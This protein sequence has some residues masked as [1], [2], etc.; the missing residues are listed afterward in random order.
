MDFLPTLWTD[1]GA[2]PRFAILARQLRISRELSQNELAKAT[3]LSLSTIRAWET[4]R[5]EPGVR[6]LVLWGRVLELPQGLASAVQSTIAAPRIWVSS[7]GFGLGSFLRERRLASGS[8]LL[9]VATDLGLA[10]TTL[11]HYETGR[12]EAPPSVLEALVEEYALKGDE[13]E[14]VRGGSRRFL[15]WCDALAADLDQVGEAVNQAAWAASA[16]EVADRGAVFVRLRTGL[17]RARLRGRGWDQWD[18]QVACLHTYWL[19]TEGRHQDAAAALA[20]ARLPETRESGRHAALLMI[21]RRHLGR[22]G[23]EQMLTLAEQVHGVALSAWLRGEAA[24]DLC[25]QRRGG[26]AKEV[27]A[28]AVSQVDALGEWRESWMR[29]RDV[30]RVA[31]RTRDWSL[32]AGEIDAMESLEPSDRYPDGWFAQQRGILRDRLAEGRATSRSVRA[33]A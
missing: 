4:G 27:V 14:A 24:L 28:Q 15:E 26:E 31:L 10:R 17:L 18:R 29:R 20:G 7:P 32:A 21:S 9:Q 23:A 12:L 22:S 2:I 13:A 16:E 11:G 8:T 1:D 30:V 3:G 25:D 6:E 5:S 19:A 33:Y